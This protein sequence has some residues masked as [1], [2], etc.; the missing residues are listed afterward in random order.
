MQSEIALFLY[1]LPLIGVVTIFCVVSF[2]AILFKP[3]VSEININLNSDVFSAPDIPTQFHTTNLIFKLIGPGIAQMVEVNRNG[4]IE[5]ILRTRK[6]PLA[7]EFGGRKFTLIVDARNY[8]QKS[9]GMTG[10]LSFFNADERPNFGNSFGDVQAVRFFHD[11]DLNKSDPVSNEGT[12]ECC[13][14]SKS[15]PCGV[16]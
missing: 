6:I 9:S 2:F 14:N 7:F 16:V 12:E 3:E 15:K 10:Y 5:T 1:Q 8:V 13:G 4:V 11:G